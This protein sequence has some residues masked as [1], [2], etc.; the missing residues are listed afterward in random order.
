MKYQVTIETGSF[1]NLPSCEE[2]WRVILEGHAY[3]RGTP[4]R[5]RTHMIGAN[6]SSL[7]V[8]VI[9]PQVDA[10]LWAELIDTILY[11]EYGVISDV[12]VEEDTE[13]DGV[14]GLVGSEVLAN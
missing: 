8:R 5:G 9:A 12:T 11:E 6:P 2:V 1:D 7:S 10:R 4:R 14:D 3:V 13:E